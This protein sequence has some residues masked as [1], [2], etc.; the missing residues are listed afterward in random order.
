MRTGAIEQ[1]ALRQLGRG[2]VP[3]FRVPV[4]SVVAH[5][6]QLQAAGLTLTEIARRAQVATSTLTRARLHGTKMSQ[7]AARAVLDVAL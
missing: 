3:A 4:S 1:H 7:I 2:R 5:V 6:E